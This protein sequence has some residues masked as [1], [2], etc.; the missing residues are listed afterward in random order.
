MAAEPLGNPH[1]FQFSLRSLFVV[2][3]VVSVLLAM[4]MPALQSA[5]ESTRRSQCTNNLKQLVLALHNYHDVNNSFPALVWVGGAPN[6][7]LGPAVELLPFYCW[8]FLYRQIADPPYN[9]GPA[10]T[11]SA[12][13][14]SPWAARLAHLR[15]PADG[16][17]SQVPS[18][19]NGPT[20][21]VYCMGD[22]IAG[23]SN[24]ALPNKDLV[25][26]RGRGI[27]AP[28]IWKNFS[29]ITDGLSN[30]VA[31]GERVIGLDGRYAIRGNI[32]QGSIAPTDCRAT[33]GSGGL[34]ATP[35]QAPCDYSSGRRWADG[36][37]LFGGFNTILPPN[38]PSCATSLT[39]V[40]DGIFSVTSNHPG[41]AGVGMGDGSVRFISEKIDAGDG[42]AELSKGPSPFG[43]WGALGSIAGGEHLPDDGF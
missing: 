18:N 5:R 9:F 3:T 30:T 15:C 14:G 21:Y 25:A 43:V 1:P 37:P 28:N 33:I 29:D 6:A 23:M 8:M 31:L 13:P 20:N 12:A 26:E 38:Y 22:S 32:T 40:T 39:E 34:Y 35:F 36:M 17:Y 4:L 27:F 41:G 24:M 42:T 11:T 10:F 19:G 2:M 16:N 7:Y